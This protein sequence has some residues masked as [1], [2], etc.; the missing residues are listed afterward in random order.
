M[1]KEYNRLITLYENYR[2]FNFIKLKIIII[3]KFK[4]ISHFTVD[5]LLKLIII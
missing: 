2:V 1:R 5:Y 3:C 4:I